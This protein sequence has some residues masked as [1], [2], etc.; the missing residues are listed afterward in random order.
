MGRQNRQLRSG[1]LMKPVRHRDLKRRV[2]GQREG[3]RQA[4]CEREIYVPAV[5]ARSP[6]PERST[7]LTSAFGDRSSNMA[8]SS[9]HIGSKNAF[10][11][12]GLLISTWATYSAG[13]DRLKNLNL[14]RLDR[15]VEEPVMLG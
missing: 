7:H 6:A 11:F 14:G 2:G 5:N 15:L 9:N 4:F 10:S 1:Y 12:S 8:F 13:N 3:E